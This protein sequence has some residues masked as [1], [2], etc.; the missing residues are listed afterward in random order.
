MWSLLPSVK[1]ILSVTLIAILVNFSATAS[2]IYL[3]EAPN[4]KAESSLDEFVSGGIYYKVT[5]VE[6][7]TVKM[8]DPW[9]KTVEFEKNVVIPGKVTW[10][11]TEYTVTSIGQYALSDSLIES[12]A[13][14]ASVVEINPFA[15]NKAKRL[16]RITVSDDNPKFC[17]VDG[18]LFSKDMTELIRFPQHRAAEVYEVPASVTKIA[19]NAFCD[20]EFVRRI[21]LSPGVVSVGTN[22]FNGCELLTSLYFPD[23]VVS[24]GDFSMSGCSNLH[25]VRF[26]CSVS[27]IE[28]C[29]FSGCTSL[30]EII[31]DGNNKNLCSIGGAVYSADAT[32][33]I[34]FPRA[35]DVSSYSFPETLTTIGGEAFKT[36][37]KL[38]QLVLPP[39]VERIKGGAFFGTGLERITIPA[40]VSDISDYAFWNCPALREINVDKNNPYF[41]SV[42]GVLYSKDMSTIFRCPKCYPDSAFK[43]PEGVTVIGTNA[44]VECEKITSLLLPASLSEIQDCAFSC[45]VKSLIIPDSVKSIGEA[46]FC[47]P[48][49]SLTIGSSVESIGS[50]A[51]CAIGEK[52]SDIICLPTVP[53]VFKEVTRYNL[54]S[55]LSSDGIF[56]DNAY[57]NAVLYVPSGCKEAYSSVEPWNKF[58]NIQELEPAK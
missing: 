28:Y 49:I 31:V 37:T 1:V 4:S 23:S 11:D 30:R 45:S 9:R 18:V 25:V 33:L 57:Q 17:D 13:V 50:N 27:E 35:K 10:Q 2:Q 43:V 55:K 26:G 20:C 53:P 5:S 21:I 40:S 52:I 38:S 56:P 48:L 12:V 47:C 22:C 29:A 34:T 8:D 6:D 46:A 36:C 24:I 41:T 32:T 3:G 39:S 7:R 15:F 58:Q 16:V 44:F 42:D 51:L 19:G 54:Y 14:P